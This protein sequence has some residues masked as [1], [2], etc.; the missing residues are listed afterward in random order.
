M[1]FRVP[2]KVGVLAGNASK[3]V[4]RTWPASL[5]TPRHHVAPGVKP[6]G[7]GV[8]PVAITFT[9]NAESEGAN[10]VFTFS[11]QAL[12]TASSDRKIVVGTVTAAGGGG[13]DAVST[14]TVGGISASLVKA[15]LSADHTQ[16]E[17]WIAAV[18]TGTTGD[19]VVT[20]N[21][22]AVRCGIGVWAMTGASATAHD[23]GGSTANPMVDTLDIPKNGAAVGCCMLTGAGTT[24]GWTNLTEDYD[25]TIQASNPHGGA[26][27]TFD[28]LQSGLSITSTPG[29]AG[30]YRAMSIASFEIG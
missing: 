21:R 25:T 23:T 30:D 7:A 4:T 27:A 3:G 28:T 11:S 6:G 15:T 2:H 9:A 26:S 18:P 1:V 14:L 22:S 12:G 13:S 16:A 29:S 8:A 17:L 19:V 24:F 20:W 10:T 5:L